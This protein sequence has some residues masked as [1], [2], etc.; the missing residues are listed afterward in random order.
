MRTALAR[1]LGRPPDSTLLVSEEALWDRHVCEP[2]QALQA[3]LRSRAA[4][5]PVPWLVRVTF[6]ALLRRLRGR[7]APY[8][9][10]ILAYQRADARAL[11]HG[12][13]DAVLRR[14]QG[15]PATPGSVPLTII[16]HSLG[17]VIAS[18]F[19]WDRRV[20]QE[21]R[22]AGY[23][24]GPF[25]LA[26][27]FTL[28]SPMAFYALKYG[29]GLERFDRPLRVPTPGCWMNFVH[30]LDPVATP[31]R[32]LNPAYRAAVSRDISV[33]NRH[34]LAAHLSYWK[35]R[36]VQRT[37]GERL[38]LDWLRDAGHPR[39]EDLQTRYDRML[40]IV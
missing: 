2:Q 19:L 35:D 27:V 34:V 13:L 37:I 9:Q 29:V 40:R 25:A 33:F 3:F 16:A 15:A 22:C 36:R 4:A 28:G 8:L 17:T 20:E 12:E 31:L 23:R 39:L 32:P 14:L 1:V 10:D 5:G 7:V 21:G 26:N 6:S 24:L 30:P 18:D 11:I 38:A